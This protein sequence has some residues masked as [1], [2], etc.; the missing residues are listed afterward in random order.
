MWFQR[1]K[2]DV[3]YEE[4]PMN[5]SFKDSQKLLTALPKTFFG[6]AKMLVFFPVD[7]ELIHGQ[8]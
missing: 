3:F 8:C 7:T 1:Q 2:T 4:Y 6:Y 5:G